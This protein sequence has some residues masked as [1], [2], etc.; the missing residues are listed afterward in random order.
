MNQWVFEPTH[1]KIG[2]SVTH[3]GITETEGHFGRFEGTIDSQANDFSDAAVTVRVDVTSVDTLDKQRDAHLLSADFFRS[4][5]HPQLT[6]VSSSMRVISLGQYKMT[7][8]LTMLGITKSIELDVEFK[9]IVPKDPFG[10]TK[11]GFKVTGLIN[12]KEW[13][14]TW[15]NRLD[16]GGLAVGNDVQINCQIEL[17]K[18]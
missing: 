3:F 5:E 11:A 1:C 10:N 15:N 17:L 8:D 13:G 6:F 2:F 9:G 16:F 7:G 12:R 4:D 14:M 18:Q